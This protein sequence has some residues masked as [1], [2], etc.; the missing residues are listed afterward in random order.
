[1][2]ALRARGALHLLPGVCLGVVDHRIG[3]GATRMR[4]LFPAAHGGNDFGAAPFGELHGVVPHRPGTAGH[5]HHG[6][7]DGTLVEQGAV[8]RHAGNAQAG[9]F[10]FADMV[11][12]LAGQFLGQADVLRRRAESPAPLAEIKPHALAD[13]LRAHPLAHRVDDARAV[14]VGNDLRIL[15]RMQA[16]GAPVH[17]GRIHRRGAQ[18]HTDFARPGQRRRELT[19][20]EHLLRQTLPLVPDCFHFAIPRFINCLSIVSCEQDCNHKP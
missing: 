9:T 19:I 1:M 3:A 20:D 8:G 7:G 13:A 10:H 6:A 16:A 11:R 14:A 15:H 2:H 5:Q 17:I 18:A 12:Q 4:G